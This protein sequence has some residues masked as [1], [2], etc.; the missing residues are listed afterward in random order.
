MK[1]PRFNDKV[2]ILF[3]GPQLEWFYFTRKQPQKL[4]NRLTRLRI[5]LI[6]I[7]LLSLFLGLILDGWWSTLFMTIS[8]VIL[9]F[10]GFTDLLDGHF[11]YFYDNATDEGAQLDPR[12]D[13][14]VVLPNLL[15]FALWSF[16]ATE[17]I[18]AATFVAMVVMASW[19]DRESDI[20]YCSNPGGR[21]NNFGKWK[22]AIHILV[23]AIG[24]ATMMV[25]PDTQAVSQIVLL[26]SFLMLA[27]N[28]CARTSLHLKQRSLREEQEEATDEPM[29]SFIEGL[30]RSV[31]TSAD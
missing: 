20:W 2:L 17:F 14:L 22:F 6:P 7:Q 13:K 19:L 25:N 21:S 18:N 23:A 26:C 15:I 12:A 5:R 27:A 10:Q 29:P 24:V 8:L 9:C 3:L 16:T 1:E 4:P 30:A 28:V 11:A 31:P